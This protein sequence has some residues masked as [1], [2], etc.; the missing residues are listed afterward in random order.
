MAST[1][2]PVRCSWLVLM[3][4]FGFWA[5]TWLVRVDMLP[6]VH[7]GAARVPA[8]HGRCA[9]HQYSQSSE[10]GQRG[11]QEAD[12]RAANRGIEGSVCQGRRPAFVPGQ[13]PGAIASQ[14]A[15]LRGGRIAAR[16]PRGQGSPQRGLQGRQAAGAGQM[17][18]GHRVAQRARGVPLQRAGRR[19]DT[20]DHRPV[21]P[22]EGDAVAAGKAAQSST[23]AGRL[24]GR[25]DGNAR[26]CAGRRRR[27][28]LP[29]WRA[30]YLLPAGRG[31]DAPGDDRAAR[32]E[33]C[34]QGQEAPSQLRP[35]RSQAHGGAGGR[36][37]AQAAPRQRQALS[38]VAARRSRARCQAGA[39]A[40]WQGPV[41]GREAIPPLADASGCQEARAERGNVR[42][43]PGAHPLR[44]TSR[45]T[46]HASC[47]TPHTSR[48][49][50]HA[51]ILQPHSQPRTSPEPLPRRRSTTSLARLASCPAAS[52]P[53]GT[54]SRRPTSSTA[55]TRWASSPTASAGSRCWRA[56]TLSSCTALSLESTTPSGSRSSS[57]VAPT[58][59]STCRRASCTRPRRCAPTWLTACRSSR[60]S[61]GWC[62]PRSR[63]T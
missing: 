40:R 60:A 55:A 47:L 20:F 17:L 1:V 24:R 26:R 21:W 32:R 15:D 43:A 36:P 52:A 16:W 41:Q 49:M 4:S 5:S 27:R 28:R 63:A 46:P 12:R 31:A 54:S 56:C 35:T 42:A 62:A 25:G 14:E 3:L 22:V 34:W 18:L 8:L 61:S 30:R 48:L 23:G 29:A 45:L 51:S 59:T 37:D 10:D 33:G 58:A 9:V 19:L 39:H 57:G 6:R 7:G 53:T 50:P 13:I 38:H 11:H 2:P 44:P